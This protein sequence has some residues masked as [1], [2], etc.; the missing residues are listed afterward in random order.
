MGITAG[1]RRHGRVLAAVAG[2]VVLAAGCAF[3]I[4]PDEGPAGT[5]V[6]ASGVGE[7]SGG[8]P[9]ADDYTPPPE[10][11]WEVEARLFSP[12]DEVVDSGVTDTAAPDGSWQIPLMIPGDAEVGDQYRVGAVCRIYVDGDLEETIG[13]E[14]RP[15]F[16]VTETTS[17]TSTTV[18]ATTTSTTVVDT[19]APPTTVGTAPEARAVDEAPAFTG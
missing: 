4:D 12:S 19:A 2:V 16:T 14:D 3:S 6:I 15:E 1:A 8:C 10:E 18:D 9:A 13:Y 17:T 5:E 7:M 11:R